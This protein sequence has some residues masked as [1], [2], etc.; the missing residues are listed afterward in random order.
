MKY[1][2]ENIYKPGMSAQ[3]LAEQ[4]L[5]IYYNGKEP[6]FPIDPFKMI[7][8]LG[9]IYQFMEFKDLEGIYIVPEDQ[10]D[11]AVIGI[12][13]KRPITR[14]RF[15]AAHEL[16]HHLKDRDSSICTI[17]SKDTNEK[18]AEQFA[19]HLLMPRKYLSKVAKMY[20]VNGYVS[21]ENALLIA[22]HFGVSFTS[23]VYTLAY[24]LGVIEGDINNNKLGK[25]C[26]KF[27]PDSKKEALGI[28]VENTLLFKQIINSY[29]FFWNVEPTLAWYKF[30]NDFIY[31][32]NRL[33]RL[34]LDEDVVAEIV[35]DL[36]FKKENSEYCQESYEEIIQVLGH[37][38]MYDYIFNTQDNLSIYKILT[39]N[40]QLYQFAPFP[41]AGGRYRTE[42]NMVTGA[43]F[44]TL[45]FKAV[46]PAIV[47]LDPEVKDLMSN[48]EK[49][50]VS[51]Y[52]DKVV[53]IHHRLTVI[54]P[55]A[56]GNGRCSRAIL[57]WM[58]RL[59]GIPPIYIKFPEKEEYYEGLKEADV[60]GNLNRLTKVFY[61]EVIRSSMQLNKVGI[62]EVAEPER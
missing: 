60:T 53:K 2:I 49:L 56:D 17:N 28:E 3:Q 22:E 11:I 29:E 48:R 33:E 34:N 16:C 58:F 20:T 10:E 35:T 15:S 5:D 9:I 37:A 36:R 55:F 52:I 38:A 23:C 42:N 19:G 30:K 24:Q 62:D 13:A 59:K 8:D 31:N 46:I 45:D 25:R 12:N 7:R 14:Q 50:E 44:E 43:E 18:Y 27:K 47:D 54:H 26:R 61:K 6:S 51:D 1:A 41:E 32:E 4:V 57:N 39:L 21:F 40:S